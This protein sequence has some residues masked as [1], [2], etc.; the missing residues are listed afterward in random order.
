MSLEFRM[1]EMFAIFRV[2]MPRSS[3]TGAEI[4]QK[5]SIDN[6]FQDDSIKIA[7]N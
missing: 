6:E 1:K 2:K 5:S 4:I 7:T 3:N